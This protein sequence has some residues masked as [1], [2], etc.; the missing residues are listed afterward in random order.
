MVIGPADV[1]HVA[2]LARLDLAEPELEAQATQLA[3]I[4]GFF[5]AMN[6]V[7]TTGIAMTAHPFPVV[8]ALREDLPRPSLPREDVLAAAPHAEAGC[9]RVPKILDA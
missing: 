2:K 6:A 9:F 3:R 1:R 5:E 4:L 8:N 7:D